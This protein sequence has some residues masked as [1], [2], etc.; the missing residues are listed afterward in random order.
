MHLH[1]VVHR[2]IKPENLLVTNDDHV[3]IIDFGVA[4][5]F[6]TCNNVEKELRDQL[7][8]T[9]KPLNLL[10]RT[11]TGLLRNTAGTIYF[12]APECTTDE[13]YNTYAVDVGV[14]FASHAQIWAVGVTLYIMVVG[15]LPLFNPDLV[16][17]FD[18]LVAKEIE[19]PASLSPEL[20]YPLRDMV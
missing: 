2:D 10:T 18:D 9:T 17:F 1:K 4:H 3:K 12:Y 6:E 5:L 13:P 8:V 19:Y 7:P 20:I 14:S 16:S 15:K 11:P